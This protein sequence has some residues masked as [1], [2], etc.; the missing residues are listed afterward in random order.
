[1]YTDSLKKII[2]G[3]LLKSDTSVKLDD[4]LEK[5]SISEKLSSLDSDE[6]SFMLCSALVTIRRLLEYFESSRLAICQLMVDLNYINI[7]LSL[8]DSAHVSIY[9][10]I[11]KLFCL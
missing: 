6:V 11:V 2:S 8:P 1:M 5:D 9:R 3:D 4:D 7:L 10:S